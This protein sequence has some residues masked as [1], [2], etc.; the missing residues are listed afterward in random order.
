MTIRKLRNRFPAIWKL[1]GPVRGHTSTPA[2]NYVQR[3]R[4]HQPR[5]ISA[6]EARALDEANRGDGPF[7]R[8]LRSGL[9]LALAVLAGVPAG[10]SAQ[11]VDGAALYGSHCAGC[12]APGADS[13]APGRDALA[14]RRPEGIVESLV[15]GA[16]RVQGSRLS[17]P[18]RRAVAEFLTGRKLGGDVVGM[19]A[20]RCGSQ[21]AMDDPTKGPAWNGWGGSLLN[22]RFQPSAAAGLT[23]TEVPKLR[24]KWA[25]GF[26][27]AAS[28]WA[29]PTVVGNRLFVGSQNGT[30]YALDPKTGCSYWSFTARGGVRTAMTVGVHPT[31]PTRYL[32]FF[33]DTSATA[34]AVDAS[35]GEEVWSRKVEDH[36]LARVT[37]APV[38]HANRV[39]FPTS[40]YEEAQSANEDY[41]CCTFRGSVTA[42]DAAS[43]RVIW[44]QYT[45][46]QAPARQPDVKGRAKWGPSGGAIWSS[47]TIDVKRGRLYVGTGNA[48]SQPVAPTTDAVLALDLESGAVRWARQLTPGDV[49]IAGCEK[50]STNSNCAVE[51]GPD[52]DFGQAPMLASQPGGRDLLVIGQKSGVG[53][54]LD[55]D[56][57]G[58]VVWQYR[59]GRGSTLGGMEWGSAAD[60][61]HAYFP[62][63]DLNIVN[64]QPGG[65]HAVRL[66][67]GERAWFA[68]PATRCNEPGCNG[69]QSAAITVIPGVVL[70]G[71]ND[72]WIRGYSTRTGEVVWEFDTNRSFDTVNGVPAKG[73]SMIGPGPV[74]VGGMLFL[75]SGYAAFGGRPGNVL[76][77]F[78][79]E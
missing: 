60:A 10:V 61:D 76:L 25:F 8:R 12:H 55:P 42:L 48:Y 32:V 27:D 22:T 72:G 40:S 31:Q 66:A 16:M 65:L 77:A 47:P 9:G 78:G 2:K 63:S 64:H 18:E 4:R 5:P 13:R 79:L 73:A 15:N 36:P 35:S 46:E 50:G 29:Q 41:E 1:N 21:L 11:A 49:Y 44:K 6:G 71:A 57:Q 24:L 7:P 17:G 53:W 54:A 14:L 38:L 37:G 75:N 33:G 59:A 34:Y 3:L 39:Y 51:M 70:S 30:V 62:V 23:A 58:A 56:R 43:G 67:T 20:G 74:V 19:A 45:I 52:Y 28:A 69:A 26:P 68:R